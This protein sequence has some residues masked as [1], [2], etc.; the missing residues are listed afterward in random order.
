MTNL[1][2]F[3]PG[4]SFGDLLTCTNN[5]SGINANLQPIQDGFGQN[6]AMQ[7]SSNTLNVVGTLQVNGI[8]IASL[9]EATRV[10]SYA[11]APPAVD[12]GIY[13]NTASSQ[14]FLCSDGINWVALG[15]P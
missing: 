2:N 13:F 7:L 4:S 15:I 9:N 6:T 1:T 8:P 10:T 11:V 3:A 14:F 12:A 5:G